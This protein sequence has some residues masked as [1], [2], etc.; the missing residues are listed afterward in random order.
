V[1]KIIIAIL[2]VT[3]GA[4]FYYYSAISSTLNIATGFAAKNICSGHFISKF[5]VNK[6]AEEALKP[7]SPAFYVVSFGVDDELM[8]V[9]TSIAGLFQRKAIYREGTG[10]TLLAIG[11]KTLD[12]KI[13]PLEFAQL[14][15]TAHWPLGDGAIAKNEDS[16]D[17]TLID[18]AIDKAF[19][20]TESVGK[21]YTKAVGIVYKGKLI[22]ERYAEDVNKNTPLLSWSMAKS[23]TSLQVALLVKAGK[24]ELLDKAE[25]PQWQGTNDPRASITLDQLMRMSSGLAF[26]ETYGINTDVSRMLSTEANAAEYAASKPLEYDPDTHW[27]YSSGTSNIISGII[28]R[29]IEGDF[30]QYYEYTQQALFKPLGIQSAIFETDASDTFIGSSYFYATARDWAKLGQLLLQNGQWNNQQIIPENWVAYSS[31]ATKTS[32]LNKYGAQF[33]LNRSPD[34]KGQ[35]SIWPTAPQDAYYMGGYQGQYVIIIPSEDLVI[36]RFGFSQSGTNRGM[37]ELINNTIAALAK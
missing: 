11:Q 12:T 17:Y 21:R 14:S 22:A 16:I 33:W 2:L 28:K 4:G 20:E 32:T 37:E 23:I 8:Q 7:I 9:N 26:N 18:Q 13:T 5:E 29:A 1:K 10:C 6:L 27:S 24:L 19:A 15:Q 3:F 35:S 30:Q 36:V 34:T 31:T 25:V